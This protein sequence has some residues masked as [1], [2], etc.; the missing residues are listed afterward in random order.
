VTAWY[1]S[2]YLVLVRLVL[3]IFTMLL[4]RLLSLLATTGLA[5]G[6]DTPE[7]ARQNYA[8]LLTRQDNSTIDAL[9][10]AANSRLPE[11]QLPAT[12]SDST[13]SLLQFMTI[14]NEIE[15]SAY[16][17]TTEALAKNA[18]G[19]ADFNRWNKTEIVGILDN[20]QAESQ[21]WLHYTT[22]LLAHYNISE[23]TGCRFKAPLT[24]FRLLNDI[25]AF[26]Q[27]NT[28][29]IDSLQDASSSLS[30]AE[31]NLI[32]I[33]WSMATTRAE[34]TAFYRLFNN[35]FPSER[36]FMTSI[37]P[38]L[39]YSS[40]TQVLRSCP[41]P[42]ST[43]YPVAAPLFADHAGDGFTFCT[44]L[45]RVPH[46]TEDLWLEITVGLQESIR[47][48][49]ANV[50]FNGSIVEFE[51]RWPRQEYILE[52]MV[53]AAL[54]EGKEGEE[55]AKYGA[56]GAAGGDGGNEALA[57][58]WIQVQ[59]PLDGDVAEPADVVCPRSG[60]TA[61]WDLIGG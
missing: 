50:S 58:I 16:H 46:E 51:A 17:N 34:Q 22:S 13:K 1:H 48:E 12:I 56:R 25:L 40:I 9:E 32:P 41:F 33:L 36:A 53:V 24:G 39:S 2:F 10:R 59:Q 38:S 31:K 7:W 30:P 26:Q 19:Y 23:A 5:L 21:L 49:V 20:H 47:V 27:L 14:W 42:L 61:F 11:V 52:G 35:E 37:P 45:S 3:L 28:L 15:V 60:G 43:I 18:T 8:K 4:S 55:N 29:F 57:A 6:N 54:R 44:D